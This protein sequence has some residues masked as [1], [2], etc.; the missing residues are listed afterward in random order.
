MTSPEL[1]IPSCNETILSLT[2]WSRQFVLSIVLLTR[3]LCSEVAGNLPITNS[4][5]SI[6]HRCPTRLVALSWKLFHIPFRFAFNFIEGTMA[7]IIFDGILT[8]Q[9]IFLVLKRVETYLSMEAPSLLVFP[10]SAVGIFLTS[11]FSFIFSKVQNIHFVCHIND[12]LPSNSISELSKKTLYFFFFFKSIPPSI[13][14]YC[15]HLSHGHK[16]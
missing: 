6:Y 10:D 15:F 9:S 3:W 13:I 12:G 1:P 8:G 14:P 5:S 16:S 11:Y 2:S 4:N 7:K